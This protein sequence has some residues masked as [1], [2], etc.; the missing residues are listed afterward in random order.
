M[1]FSPITRMQNIGQRVR[2]A[3]KSFLHFAENFNTSREILQLSMNGKSVL[4]LEIK[5]GI[6][7]EIRGCYTLR[8]KLCQF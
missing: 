1:A 8:L 6:F 5:T 3:K 4:T 7:K 2:I